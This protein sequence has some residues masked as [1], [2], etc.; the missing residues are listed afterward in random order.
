MI[1]RKKNTKQIKAII[2]FIIF[3]SSLLG[4][5][6]IKAA[7]AN[8]GSLT[9]EVTYGFN[10]TTKMNAHT[11]FTISISNQGSEIQ[12]VVQV[13]LSSFTE[14]N[15]TT[16]IVLNSRYKEK[17]YMYQ[18]NVTIVANATT[19]VT[20]VIPVTNKVNKLQITVLDEYG[21]T[22]ST[23]EQV[24]E[25]DYFSYYV[26][27]AIISD[28][29][30][31]LNYF[32]NTAIYQYSDYT[33][34]AIILSKDDIP[35]DNYGL[36]LFDV[37]IANQS[38]IDSL[39]KEQQQVLDNW[40]K[41]DGLMIDSDDIVNKQNVSW[42][43]IIPEAEIQKL[44]Y[45]YSSYEAWSISSALGNVYMSELPNFMLYVIVISIYIALMGPMLYL[46][47][48]K[49]N[50]RYLFW[51]F[52]IAGAILFA[53]IIIIMGSNTRLKAPFINYF[54]IVTYNKNTIDDSVYFNIR[55]PFNNEYKLYLDKA[56]SF[57]PITEM[58]YIDNPSQIKSVADYN[59]GISHDDKESIITVKNDAAFTKEYFYAE[60][61]DEISGTDYININMNLFGNKVTG[62]V[63]NNLDY[64]IEN[65][66]ILKYNK[67]IF[68]DTIPANTTVKIDNFPI[69]TY[70][71]KFKYG[72]TNKIAKLKMDKRGV[73]QEGCMLQ[74]QKKN[75]MDF[76]L[77]KKF[78]IATDKTYLIGFTTASNQL[79]MQLDSSYDAYGMTMIEV[80]CDV[81][82]TS[83]NHQYT[84][85][86]PIKN[87]EYSLSGDIMYSDE[88]I[89]TYNLGSN[90][91]DINLYF[92]ELSYYDPQYYKAFTGHVY[93]YNRK[94]SLYDPFDLSKM[95][96]ST[97]DLTQYLN[98]DNEIVIKYVEHFGEEEKQA[99]LPSLSTIGRIND[100]EN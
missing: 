42:E 34:K 92:N 15:S 57:K 75:I 84:A 1:N 81:N 74:N 73:I 35:K 70:N 47:L 63:T 48:K 41:N 16:D 85:Y 65:A 78:S 79:D 99:L 50:K 29:P 25:S 69:Y 100:V 13:I 39:S 83:N 22:L 67:V 95:Y 61:S 82:Y 88:M 33:F 86:V 96:I 2:C 32:E 64:P 89:L 5:F 53:V 37:I 36:E 72:L 51:I 14:S 10:G 26:Y 77:E 98:E 20:M 43:N 4:S 58:V 76:Y 3:C 68:L 6:N 28:D 11:P 60:K 49:L 40:K 23:K 46:I 87:E 17:N 18:E 59:I 93:F 91:T 45:S 90:L 52:E 94:T 30:I 9:T 62:S 31:V 27:A 7:A 54:D 12:G 56:Y 71:P 8:V 97:Q 38:E 19:N 44:N 24:I 66:T 80:P 21:K 55:A